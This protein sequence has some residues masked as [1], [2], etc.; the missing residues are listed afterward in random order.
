MQ[1]NREMADFGIQAPTQKLTEA[2]IKRHIMDN[3]PYEN[4]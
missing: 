4:E 2:K 1:L 3:T